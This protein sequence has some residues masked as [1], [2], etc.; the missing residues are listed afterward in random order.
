MQDFPLIVP[1]FDVAGYGAGEQQPGPPQRATSV[2]V[3]VVVVPSSVRRRQRGRA[4]DADW[5]LVEPDKPESVEAYGVWKC[6]ILC[7]GG[8]QRSATEGWMGVWRDVN[9]SWPLP[10]VP[11]YD[12]DPG[13]P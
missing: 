11:C 12:L 4:D 1:H 10:M 5:A 13:M 2:V 9:R 3:V 6:V 8:G 7:V